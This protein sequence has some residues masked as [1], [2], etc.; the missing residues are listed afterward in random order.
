MVEPYQC[1][2]RNQ[3]VV[4]ERCPN[5]R[6][7]EYNLCI[8]P[9]ECVYALKGL[10]NAVRCP[11]KIM[12][13]LEKRDKMRFCDFNGDH[14]HR[15]NECIALKFEIVKLLRKGYLVDLLTDTRK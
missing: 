11:K 3:P 13:V 8:S 10:G 5:R 15:T 6:I 12:S 9:T 4:D 7:P 2:Y 1:N 14:S